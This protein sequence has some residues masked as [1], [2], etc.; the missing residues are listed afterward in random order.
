M[1]HRAWFLAAVLALAAGCGQTAPSTP[2]ER[3]ELLLKETRYGEAIAALTEAI[4]QNPSDSAPY[5]TRGRAY[6][7]RDE[8]GDVD[9]AI[10]DFTSAIR[11]RPNDPEPYYSRSIAYRDL[12]D[13]EKS[14]ADDEM[15]RKL[16]TRIAEEYE[17]LPN[18]SPPAPTLPETTI[19]EAEPPTPAAQLE[20]E[21]SAWSQRRRQIEADAKREQKEREDEDSLGTAASRTRGTRPLDRKRSTSAMRARPTVRDDEKELNEMRDRLTRPA[22]RPSLPAEDPFR[23][24][25]A[26]TGRPIRGGTLPP[27]RSIMP[28]TPVAPG[29]S[30]ALPQ[31][32]GGA[33]YPTPT[34]N[35]YS[36]P[37]PQRRPAPTGILPQRT[38]GAEGALPAQTRPAVGVPNPIGANHLPGA[39][40]GDYNP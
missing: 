20:S 21:D 22:E 14:R 29:T 12:G 17:H 5:L 7:C 18:T 28:G 25:G 4:R 9:A 35:P 15:A 26:L 10:A 32:A 40:H 6:Q 1:T 8:A 2:L 13:A 39:Q 27:T 31:Q 30:G 34:T 37:F 38:Q 24:S 11:F 3:G 33:L 23:T 16:D 19:V 36:S